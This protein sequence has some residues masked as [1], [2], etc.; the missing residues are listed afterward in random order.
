MTSPTPQA[1]RSAQIALHWFVMIG[2]VVQ[3]AIHEPMVRAP[4]A[5]MHGLTG[6]LIFAAVLVRL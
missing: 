2:V 5:M 1:Y 6:T 3:I 4:L